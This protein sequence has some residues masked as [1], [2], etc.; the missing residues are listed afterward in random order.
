MKGLTKR[1]REILDFIEN[2]ITNNR[3]SPSYREIGEF[4]GFT[5]LGSVFKHINALKSKGLILN[6]SKSSR[7]IAPIKT[8]S[9]TTI[10]NTFEIPFIGTIAAGEAIQTFPHSQ[11]ITVERNWVHNPEKTYALRARG[12]SLNE[13]MIADGDILVI[14]ARQYAK[15]GETVIA[16]INGHDTIVKRYYPDDDFVKL[17]SF[18]A[19]HSPIILQHEDIVIQGVLISLLRLMNSL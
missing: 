16:L 5:S 4:F 19:H 12:N 14:E 2:F 18:H 17:S 7:S 6:D 11:Q 15:S 3:Y 10:E 13:E 9:S 1:Q 8:D